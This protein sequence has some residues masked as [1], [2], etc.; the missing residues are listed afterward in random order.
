MELPESVCKER[1]YL[2]PLLPYV[3]KKNGKLV[4]VLRPRVVAGG[5][6]SD[7]DEDTG[8]ESET[9]LQLRVKGN[10]VESTFTISHGD[11]YPQIEVD[12]YSHAIQQMYGMRDIKWCRINPDG[13]PA[14]PCDL[15]ECMKPPRPV[16]P[17]TEHSGEDH[18]SLSDPRL[19]R[20]EPLVGSEIVCVSV[21]LVCLPAEMD[22]SRPLRLLSTQGPSIRGTGR[23]PPYTDGRT[24]HFQSSPDTE[25]NTLPIILPC[26]PVQD[27]TYMCLPYSE[28]QTLLARADSARRLVIHSIPKAPK[29]QMVNRESATIS[30]TARVAI[31]LLGLPGRD[32][33]WYVNGAVGTM[34]SGKTE[35]SEQCLFK[36]LSD[37]AVVEGA[38]EAVSLYLK[39]DY[40]VVKEPL[41]P[42]AKLVFAL[43]YLLLSGRFVS[44]MKDFNSDTAESTLTERIQKCLVP[45]YSA[46]TS[47]SEFIP[48]CLNTR[49]IEDLLA[50][51]APVTQHKSGTEIREALSM[52]PWRWMQLESCTLNE[53]NKDSA[54][55]KETYAA[56]FSDEYVK[57]LLTYV[58][59]VLEPEMSEFKWLP[60]I[61]FVDEVTGGKDEREMFLFMRES[62]KNRLCFFTVAG[63]NQTGISDAMRG[64][65]LF[66]RPYR[67]S[68]I[69]AAEDIVSLLTMRHYGFEKGTGYLS[70]PVS[71]M[72]SNS[73]VL[74]SALKCLIKCGGNP[75]IIIHTLGQYYSAS[76][77]QT[78]V[79]KPV[80]PHKRSDTYSFP[81]SEELESISMCGLVLHT[82]QSVSLSDVSYTVT[83]LEEMQV[84]LNPYPDPYSRAQ[85]LGDVVSPRFVCIAVPQILPCQVNVPADTVTPGLTTRHVSLP[86]AFNELAH[87]VGANAQRVMTES[88]NTA[89][90]KVDDF[91]MYLQMALAA[92]WRERIRCYAQYVV[93][94][95]DPISIPLW[96]L[97][98]IP[99]DSGRA[100]ALVSGGACVSN[101][102]E[103]LLWL[104]V[105]RYVPLVPG[106]VR[107]FHFRQGLGGLETLLGTKGLETVHKIPKLNLV[108]ASAR[109]YPKLE[110][111]G[112]LVTA[113]SIPMGIVLNGDGAPAGDIIMKDEHGIIAIDSLQTNT[114][115]DTFLDQYLKMVFCL[116]VPTLVVSVCT[117]VIDKSAVQ[118]ATH[119]LRLGTVGERYAAIE[120]YIEREIA[121][122]MEGGAK[123]GE[124]VECD[125]LDRLKC[126]EDALKDECTRMELLAVPHVILGVEAYGPVIGGLASFLSR[127][128]EVL[129]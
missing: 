7:S 79:W 85:R 112:K 29:R 6:D 124:V 3:E 100:S 102:A 35:F 123:D 98:G 80:L 78:H 32:K 45:T 55:F 67:L 76:N 120:S 26:V 36:V 42:A 126:I 50:L 18:L 60:V 40:G 46:M 105:K 97:F 39:E 25:A 127:R 31:Q 103:R 49:D 28:S 68:A 17:S 57:G 75:R 115:S 51:S 13:T 54:A 107:E 10:D 129:R 71:L 21:G 88:D 104:G 56:C 38:I 91:S 52:C 81:A 121:A 62:M 2:V 48:L 20:V 87:M 66:L 122:H 8:C 72:D 61:V 113:D 117:A 27:T 70:E 84:M 58:V 1:R 11:I 125:T 59:Q 41:Q 65:G 5:V 4:P 82:D 43:Q 89:R 63:L 110:A 83:K 33:R 106:S 118:G 92:V 99:Q 116:P 37:A 93:Y 95:S 74:P 15:F 109:L 19:W 9:L 73:A 69:T 22:T 90:E 16:T 23:H 44:V 14:T 101:D 94:Q 108:Y 96:A 119:W 47:L 128:A 114:E 53:A 86:V 12:P 64:S 24:C 77:K 30:Y 34:G 111:E